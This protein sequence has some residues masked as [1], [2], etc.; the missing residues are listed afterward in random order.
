MLFYIMLSIS[1]MKHLY[2]TDHACKCGYKLRLGC[3]R[4]NEPSLPITMMGT[5]NLLEK[6]CFVDCLQFTLLNSNFVTNVEGNSWYKVPT[7]YTCC[8]SMLGTHLEHCRTYAK[9]LV[10]QAS[11]VHEASVGAVSGLLS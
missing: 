8:L 5:V 11:Q 6:A 4:Q 2:S 3:R 1:Q 9:W 10:Y 7:I